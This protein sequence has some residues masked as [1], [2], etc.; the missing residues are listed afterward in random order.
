MG[1]RDWGTLLDGFAIVEEDD[2]GI[3]T[4]T[5]ILDRLIDWKSSIPVVVDVDVTF[6]DVN[7]CWRRLWPVSGMIGDYDDPF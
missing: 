3:R 4:G 1:V 2:L 7:G 5:D 6:V